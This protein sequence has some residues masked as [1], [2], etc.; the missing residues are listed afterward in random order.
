[1]R[2][3]DESPR[4]RNSLGTR[5]RAISAEYIPVPFLPSSLRRPSKF[6]VSSPCGI[7]DS[8]LLSANPSLPGSGLAPRGAPPYFVSSADCSTN[9]A[10]SLSFEKERDR[11]TRRCRTISRIARIEFEASRL[12]LCLTARWNST[13]RRIRNHLWNSETIILHILFFSLHSPP[14]PPPAFTEYNDTVLLPDVQR[15]RS[16]SRKRDIVSINLFTLR[17]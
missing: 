10:I 16:V 3:T 8:P 7:N 14:P 4:G 9:S 17:A 13:L 1:M 2:L 6:R 15:D 11:G 5:A 12:A